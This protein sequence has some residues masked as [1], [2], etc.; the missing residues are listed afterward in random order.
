M[1]EGVT[2]QVYEQDVPI[3]RT[4]L[5]QKK[6]RN[7]VPTLHLFV[8]SENIRIRVVQTNVDDLFA[9]RCKLG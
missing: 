9:F 1:G 6:T 4:V 2:C 5:V 7:H 8:K 3:R